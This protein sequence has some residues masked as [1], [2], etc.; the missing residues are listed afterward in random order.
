[1]DNPRAQWIRFGDFELDV[2]AGELRRGGTRIRLQEQ[3]FQILL[4]LLEKPGAVITREQVQ[5][6]LWPNDTIV[7]FDHSIGTAVKK[8]RQA[9]GDEAGSPRYV[10]TLPRRGFRLVCPEV[11]RPAQSGESATADAVVQPAPTPL[12][13]PTSKR[14]LQPAL[15]FGLAVFAGVAFTARFWWPHHPGETLDE[16]SLSQV[17]TSIGADITPSLSPDG[18]AVA[19]SSD[20]SGSFEIYV[21][22]LAPGGREVQLTSDGNGN[23]EPAWSPDGTQIAYFS[24]KKGGIWLIPALGG[25]ARRLTDFGSWPAWSPDG[26]RIVFQSG[27]RVDFSQVGYAAMPP[28]TLWTVSAQGGAPT[29]LTHP[30]NPGGGHGA[31]T[32]SPD[33][34][35]IAFTSTS[36]GLQEIWTISANGG[37]PQRVV[38]GGV[39][40]PAFGPGSRS[41][42]FSKWYVG[43]PRNPRGAIMFALMRLPLTASGAAAGAAELVMTSGSVIYRSLHFSADGRLL[44]FSA[45]SANNNM[46][47]IRISPATG[48]AIG[49]PVAFTHDTTVRKMSPRFSPDGSQVAY[50]E[51]QSGEDNVNIWIA[52]ADGTNARPLA[53]MTTNGLLPGWLPAGGGLVFQA[54]QD[55]QK[56]LD[57]INLKSGTIDLLRA[58]GPNDAPFRISPDGNQVAY[59]ERQGSAVNVWVAPIDDKA[60]PA[61]QLTFGNGLMSYPSWSPDGKTIAFEDGSEIAIVP[62][63]GGPVTVLAAD[64]QPSFVSDWAPDNDKIVF[65]GLRNGVWN[66]WWVSRRTRQEKQLTHYTNENEYV[67]YPAWS[68][69]GDQIVYEYAET[70]ANIW[71]MRVK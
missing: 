8:L 59:G 36:T 44:V 49:D 23:F 18:S 10:E 35:L 5:Q 46:Q 38:A 22:T 42:Y 21:K 50:T 11:V 17:T 60:G 13:Q 48:E 7:E 54:Q 52:G 55:G 53:D 69:R 32:W 37:T 9:L 57:V 14:R 1:M 16:S 56:V 20:K 15:L 61:R 30:G 64:H 45:V 65:A 3:P 58:F 6:R 28:S 29:Q 63:R 33:G 68:P 40:D 47:S 4:M 34:R 43:S 26:S 41:L 12:A 2:R 51:V 70:T 31:P 39:G 24:R 71:T 66:I 19:Y 67:R 27:V 62:A 25:A